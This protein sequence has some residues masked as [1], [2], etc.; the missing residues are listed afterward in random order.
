MNNLTNLSNDDWVD[1]L[2]DGQPDE[3]QEC[4]NFDPNFAKLEYLLLRT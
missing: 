3:A 1:Y 4:Q 2:D